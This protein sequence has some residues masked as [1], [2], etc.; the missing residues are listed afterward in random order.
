MS[1]LF[2]WLLI[3]RITS[4]FL[5]I[6]HIAQVVGSDMK[7]FL[8]SIMANVKDALIQRGCVSLLI[9]AV[10]NTLNARRPQKEERP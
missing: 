2:I 4:A 7:P 8:D 9:Y 10:S 6:G 3:S 5:A 1:R